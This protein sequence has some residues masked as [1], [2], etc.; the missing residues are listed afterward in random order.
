M[1]RKKL[2]IDKWYG[3][4]S[5]DPSIWWVWSFNEWRWVEIRK[6]SRKV[7]LSSNN[8]QENVLNSRSNGYVIWAMIES[9]S[10]GIVWTYDGGISSVLFNEASYWQYYID[11]TYSTFK[12][13]FRYYW[14]S[15]FWVVVT[16]LGLLRWNINTWRSDMWTLED[17]VVTSWDFSSDTWWSIWPNWTISWWVA[18]H[19]SWNTATLSQTLTVENATKYIV[20][21]S[22]NCSAWSLDVELWWATLWT[23]T[24]ANNNVASTYS[25]TTAST[26]ENLVL[27]PTS[28]FVWSI[29][30]VYVQKSN[31]SLALSKAFTWDS[32]LLST[33]NFIYIGNW[34]TLTKVDTSLSSWSSSDPVTIAQWYTIKWLS[35]VWDQIYIYASN[36]SD[37]K[38][39]VWDSQ[40][41]TPSWEITWYDKPISRVI[42]L[43]NVD[44][45]I[46][47]T[48]LRSSL[49]KVNWYQPQLLYQSLNIQNANKDRFAFDPEYINGF[50]TIWQRLLL[51]SSWWLYSFGNINPWYPLSI[52][53]EYTWNGWTPTTVYYNESLYNIYIFYKSSKS[54]SVKNYYSSFYQNEEAASSSD[55]AVNDPWFIRLQPFYWTWYSQ[56]KASVWYKIWANIPS[57][58]YVNIYTRSDDQLWYANFYTDPNEQAITVMPQVWAV[59]TNWSNTYTVSSVTELWSWA[60]I[61][62][63]Y[64]WSNAVSYSGTLTK[65]SWTWDSTIKFYRS[66]EFKLIKQLS[67]SDRWGQRFQYP[68]SYNK[69]DML[70]E[71][72]TTSNQKTPELYDLQY[73][74][75]EIETD[76]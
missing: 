43:N 75:D 72:L 45:I 2:T 59:Y 51:P 57:W 27:R 48:A 55:Y 42:N 19:T 47:K 53:K 56:R 61:N 31:I 25:R 68:E 12:N 44:Y 36:W 38:Q 76:S 4:M 63:T 20:N 15:D 24:S 49:Y 32:V 35:K 52:L 67:N 17:S 23:I 28:D 39:Y 3:W 16:P 26:S 6:D 9:N 11:S 34:Q 65:S 73:L 30:F 60:V 70:V 10:V 13:I 74:F 7:K 54:W 14:T 69:L 40:S 33:P 18:S 21:I 71:L 66:N 22:T 46:V 37:G 8:W 62:C 5:S 64:T 58:T 41:T 1:A 50:E 29:E